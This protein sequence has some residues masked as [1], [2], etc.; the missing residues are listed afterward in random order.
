[1]PI[2][3]DLLRRMLA[4]DHP[5][6]YASIILLMD[7]ENLNAVSTVTTSVIPIRSKSAQPKGDHPAARSQ[8][9]HTAAG[10]RPLQWW[11]V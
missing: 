7:L 3:K 11:R 10:N 1:M 8:G 4:F 5:P 6:H 2:G 9:S